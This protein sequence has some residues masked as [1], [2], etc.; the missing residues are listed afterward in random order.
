VSGTTAVAVKK[1]LIEALKTAPALAGV[2]VAYSYPG[3]TAQREIVYGGKVTFDQAHAGARAGSRPARDETGTV[4]L[5]VEVAQAGN[6][7]AYA[8]DLRA[9]VI[10][11]AI[12]EYVEGNLNLG[13]LAGLL[14]CGMTGG[15]LESATNDDDW[16]SYLVYR[17]AFRSR[18][19]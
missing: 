9:Q 14:F 12:E 10:G 7:D 18:I 11:T 6:E 16:T 4:T 1:A 17:V 13:G 5:I 2:Q 3:R 15:E 19:V 8:S